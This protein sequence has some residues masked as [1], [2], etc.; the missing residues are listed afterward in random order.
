[1][2]MPGTKSQDM[3][4]LGCML[5]DMLINEHPFEPADSLTMCR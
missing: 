2:E 1:M 5:A 3:W 4:S